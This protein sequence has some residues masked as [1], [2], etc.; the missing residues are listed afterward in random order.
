MLGKLS[1]CEEE[2]LDIGCEVEALPDSIEEGVAAI[3]D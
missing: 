1:P 3:K 2:E